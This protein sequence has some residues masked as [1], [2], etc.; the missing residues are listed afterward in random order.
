MRVLDSSTSPW[1]HTRVGLGCVP[2]PEHR[3]CNANARSCSASQPSVVRPVVRCFCPHAARPMARTRFVAAPRWS[4]I[5]IV[6]SY[7]NVQGRGEA[8]L[9]GPGFEGSQVRNT[10]RYRDGCTKSNALRTT[11]GHEEGPTR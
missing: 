11:E 8:E 3:R 9:V 4:L 10:Q 1:N 2:P 7:D 6:G 5:R